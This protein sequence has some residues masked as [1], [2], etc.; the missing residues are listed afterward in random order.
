[1]REAHA[2]ARVSHPNVVAVHEVGA[3]DERVFIV[4]EF[5]VGQTLRAWA[6]RET[7][8]WRES[9]E[10][11]LQAGAGLA[12]AHRASLV[13]RDFKPDNAVLGADGRVR[14]IDFGLA[15]GQ[16]EPCVDAP[17]NEAVTLGRSGSLGS[18]SG[19]THTVAASVAASGEASRVRGRTL[20]PVD[21]RG[22]LSAS[23]TRPGAMLGTPAYMSPEQF[24]GAAVGPASD[25]FSFCLALYEAVFGS[26]AF[27]GETFIELQEN[28][29]RGRVLTPSR[30]RDAPSWLLDALRRGLHQEP[31]A[32]WSSMDELIAA[33]SR[34]TDRQR[35]RRRGALAFA[36]L[37]ALGLLAGAR[38]AEAERPCAGAEQ[39]LSGAWDDARR[40]SVTAAVGDAQLPYAAALAP[41]LTRG[42]DD[43]AARWKDM[44]LESC[45]AHQRGEQ[46]GARLDQR[47]ACLR[48]HRAALASA[49]EVL[50]E[51]AGRDLENAAYMV[52]RL[53]AVDACGDPA[54]LDARPP[55][56]DPALA[57]ALEL[58]RDALAR[59]GTLADI[60]RVEAAFEL[61]R[62][63]HA[64]ALELEDAPLRAEALL[65]RG[66]VE[67]DRER[68][69]PASAAETLRAAFEQAIAAD[70]DD[71]AAEAFARWLYMDGMGAAGADS[72][73]RPREDEALARALARRAPGRASIEGL[74]L[75]NLGALHMARGQL[76][77]ARARFQEALARKQGREGGRALERAETRFNLALV[78]RELPA[79]RAQ[80]DQSLETFQ[81]ELGALH[82]K[83]LVVELARAR[84]L[85]DPRAAHE[86]L[87]RTCSRLGEAYPE[88]LDWRSTCV[89]RQA[90]QSVEL[91]EPSRARAELQT[92]ERLLA[93]FPEDSPAGLQRALAGGFSA[94]LS[95]AHE[96]AI[97]RFDALLARPTPEAAAGWLTPLRVEAQLGRAASLLA[98]GRA[99]EANATLE[100]AIAW[101]EP[102]S[103]E[104]ADAAYLQQLARARALARDA[105]AS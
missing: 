31:A 48:R 62:R 69:D 38:L 96:V 51:P 44:F 92:V 13:H 71:I 61:A 87:T 4:M 85:T 102:A 56:D 12:A 86:Q 29:T 8:S 95:G 15:R 46:S 58:E 27:A 84:T 103:R 91:G 18:I 41:R 39:A 75:N 1:M 34:D 100:P 77:E 32:R 5:V 80:L 22:P 74:L 6:E 11:Y 72:G 30:Q 49:A 47:M 76:D 55:P 19:L 67:I 35:R 79:A 63:V 37:G 101:L 7:R 68:A 60:G 50:S 97:T 90:M 94:A 70:Q 81:R 36:G 65:L 42:L 73:L 2:L 82:P 24:S 105:E 59:A 66:R 16:R 14:V 43:Y 25:Q 28:V 23:L 17:A 3:L 45:M 10:V 98:L 88:R 40:A 93:E 99:A 20:R 54:R 26:R 9:L 53:P 89:Y 83:S 78:E 21:E 33:L 52:Q 57:R 104:R 64:R